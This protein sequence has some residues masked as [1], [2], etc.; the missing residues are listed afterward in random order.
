MQLIFRR[1]GHT[2]TTIATAEATK[3]NGGLDSSPVGLDVM[4]S[5]ETRILVAG[6]AQRMAEKKDRP[7]R[8]RRRRRA[9]AAATMGRA[10]SARAD[11]PTTRG[12]CWH[13]VATPTLAVEGPIDPTRPGDLLAP[14]AASSTIAR[15]S[16]GE[17][18][19]A[20]GARA[21]PEA[22]RARARAIK[23]A[24]PP[25]AAPRIEASRHSASS[26]TSR[27]SSDAARVRG[28]DGGSW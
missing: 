1:R 18:R 14:V 24:R 27:R 16:A 25:G 7:P 17:E 2:G 22:P 6:D 28:D 9:R 12:G 5:A 19:R 8:A 3:V 4:N 11:R 26:A 21:R 10:A 23:R 15:S 20:A 13:Q